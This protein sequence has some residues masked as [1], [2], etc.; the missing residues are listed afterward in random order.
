MKYLGIA[1]LNAA[2]FARQFWAATF[3]AL[4]LTL[5]AGVELADPPSVEVSNSR[6]TIHWRTDVAAGTRIQISPAANILPGDKTPDTDHTVTVAALRSG[7]KY[8][9]VVG[10]ARVWLATNEFTVSGTAAA[11]PGGAEPPPVVSAKARLPDAPP[12]RK[13]WGNL[14]SLPDHFA[15]H[16]ADFGAKN[17]DDYAR[18]AWEFLQRAKAE[19]LPAKVDDEGVLRIYDS[20]SGTFASY[21][22]DGTAKTFFKPGSHGYFERQPGR[23]VKLKP[24]P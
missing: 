6:A 16:G 23:T 2:W 24:Q 8:T 9:V 19:S 20:K 10:T 4:S 14:P 17:P 21:N 15:R 12:T 22:A 11:A 3:F 18:Q 7:V 1:R 5:V 13:I